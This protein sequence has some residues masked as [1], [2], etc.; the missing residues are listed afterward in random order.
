MFAGLFFTTLATLMLEIGLT[1]IF[2]VSMWYH[3]SFMAISIAMFGLSAGAMI[4]QLF[5]KHFQVEDVPKRMALFGI[6]FAGS[7]VVSFGLFL[8]IRFASPDAFTPAALFPLILIYFVT[9]IPFIM[10][11]IL[12]CL[13]LT[14]F[15]PKVSKLYAVDLVGSAVGCICLIPLL[16]FLDG[17]TA[18]IAIAALA[19]LGAF[20]FGKNAKHPRLIQIAMMLTL[21]LGASTLLH[22]NLVQRGTPVFQ[23][24][25]IKGKAA[26]PAL[27]KKW[28]AYSRIAVEGDP[29]KRRSPFGWGMSWVLPQHLWL[30]NYLYLNIDADAGT[31]LT[32]FTGDLKD[33]EHLKYDVTN[34]VHHIKPNADILV[35]GAGGGRD[36]LSALAFNQKSVTAIEFNH[37]ILKAVH[38]EF[39]DFTGHLDR[40]PKVRFVQDEARSF[41][42]REKR[43]YDVIQSSFIDTWAAT[44]AGA[45]VLTENG[46]YTIDAW[47]NFL[48][49]LSPGGIL[50]FS[51][52]Y[53]GEEPTETYRLMALAVEAL[54]ATGIEDTRKHLILIKNKK[55]GS[56]LVKNEPFSLQEIKIM[57]RVSQALR[58]EVILTPNDS[59]NA[60]IERIANGKDL[61]SLYRGFAF[62][63]RPPTDDKP[64]F[65][66]IHKPQNLFKSDKSFKRNNPVFVLLGLLLTVLILTAIVIV[67]PLILASKG[68]RLKGSRGFLT[69]FGLIGLAFMLVEISQMQ[70][71]IVFLGHPIFGL[72]T[73]LFSLLLASG[74]GSLATS[75]LNIE[76]VP[77]V[78]RVFYIL[79]ALLAIFLFVTPAVIGYFRSASTPVRIFISLLMIMPI[80]FFM[81]M[82]FPIALK[83]ASRDS[84]HPTAWFWAVNGA[85]S[86]VGSVLAFA[87]ALF[88]G[89]GASFFIGLICYGAA[90]CVILS[91]T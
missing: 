61:E 36:V 40:H 38:E 91:K 81:G 12:I 69:Y 2:S 22:D 29:L 85:T 51:R 78:R 5:P 14:K 32:R 65:F 84:N 3:F 58:Y 73:I 39:G 70:R 90:L 28:N 18:M 87:I 59:A 25:W 74:L 52:W 6:F 63:I 53:L 54:Q 19:S 16:E 46:L 26:K 80:G 89:I 68:I 77:C 42:A 21:V 45:Y 49:H 48:A 23:L 13:A 37:D 27:Y 47:K 55:V 79:I 86:V 88:M 83:L 35:I 30:T 62:N 1:R 72:S 10:S 44:A 15:P 82:P 56:L 20:F 71:L 76:D 9:L 75:R 34:V 8:Q 17:P 43:T 57:K 67:L 33:A 41:I 31:V 7:I 50:T 66:Q 4:V 24:K 11:G 60:M 64:F